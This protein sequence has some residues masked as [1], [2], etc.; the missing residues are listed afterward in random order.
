MQWGV[1]VEIEKL[2]DHLNFCLC[3]YFFLKKIFKV[4]NN[5]LFWVRSGLSFECIDYDTILFQIWNALEMN[6]MHSKTAMFLFVAVQVWYT[7]KPISCKSVLMSYPPRFKESLRGKA[8]Q[9]QMLE[10]R[11]YKSGRQCAELFLFHCQLTR[12]IESA[13]PLCHVAV[14]IKVKRFSET[15]F[16]KKSLVVGNITF[17]AYLIST[18]K[19]MN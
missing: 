4:M 19:I 9:K 8:K 7:L 5:G 16:R 13:F 14:R 10:K 11:C 15:F 3:C 1:V 17:G 12:E 18:I 6:V 2:V